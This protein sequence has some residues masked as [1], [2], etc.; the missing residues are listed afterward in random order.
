MTKI[1]GA[2]GLSLTSVAVIAFG[3]A[4][5]QQLQSVLL[6]VG[7]AL[8]SEK[9]EWLNH[10][11]LQALLL[12]IGYYMAVLVTGWIFG[13]LARFFRFVGIYS[14]ASALNSVNSVVGG[15]LYIALVVLAVL[16]ILRVLKGKDANLP[17]IAKMAGGD[18]A[19]VLQKSP[20]AESAPTSFEQPPDQV[21]VRQETYHGRNCTSCGAA[22]Q[23]DSRFCTQCGAKNE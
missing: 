16:A 20:K 19:T 4:M 3:F 9:D 1:K 22:L 13:G 2:Y 5:L 15:I 21:P 8:V 12:T 23:E 10:Q 11:V 18:F 17:F 14:G 6:V 7:F